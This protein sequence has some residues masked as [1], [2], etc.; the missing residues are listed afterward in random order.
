MPQLSP[1]GSVFPFPQPVSFGLPRRGTTLRSQ[2]G[3][4]QHGPTHPVPMDAAPSALLS[5]AAWLLRWWGA[6]PWPFPLAL[7]PG[8][9]GQSGQPQGRWWHPVLIFIYWAEQMAWSEGKWLLIAIA[10]LF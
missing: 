8:A 9:G 4:G 10:P 7:L 6:T 2:A 5:R 1:N 3:L